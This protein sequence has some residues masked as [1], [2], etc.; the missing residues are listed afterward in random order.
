M[1]HP[2]GPGPLIRP[3]R[4]RTDW[5]SV[6]AGIGFTLLVVVAFRSSPRILQNIDGRVYDAFLRRSPHLPAGTVPV[7]VDIDEESLARYGQWPW[8]RY[9]VAQLLE[10]VRDL[11]ASAVALDVVFAEPDRTSLPLI[12]REIERDLGVAV[13]LGETAGRVADNDQR[14]A[15]VLEKGPFVL[16]Y[17]FDFGPG[18]GKTPD[19]CVLHPLT[20]NPS[21]RG[22]WA[23]LVRAPQVVCNL[24]Q[25]A[26]AAGA[27]GFFNVAPDPDGTLR[28]V[29]LLIEYR[30]E[31][32]PSL[33]LA[34][35]VRAGGETTVTLE[36]AGGA[37][38]R[39]KVAGREI[40]LGGYGKML[41][42]F[43]GPG[44][45]YR[46]LS[47]AAVLEG[48]VPAATLA[49]RIAFV[50]TTAAGLKEL[51]ATPFDP[52]YP[53]PEVHAAALDTILQGD[54]LQRPRAAHGWELLAA[55]FAGAL[56]TLV[57][58]RSGA[59]AGLPL[60]LLGSAA[61][62]GGSF[63]LFAREG[64]FVSPLIPQSVLAGTFALLSFLRFRQSER[65]AAAFARKLSLTQ[66]VIIQSMAA[67]AETRDSGTGGHIQRTRHYVKLLA[68]LLRNH[69]RFREYLDPWTIELLY[70]LAP[71]HDIGKVGVRDHVLLKPDRLSS[72][73]FEEMK[74][75]TI[76]GDNTLELAERHLGD[77]SFLKIAR[78]FAL[79]HQEKWDGTGYPQDL[80]GEQIPIAGRLMAVADVYDALVS[81][82]KYKE[83]LSHE[84]AVAILAEGRGT[85]FDPDVLDVFLAHQDQF[86]MIAARFADAPGTGS[87]A[88]EK[89]A[90]GDG[91]RGAV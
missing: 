83:P 49:G 5:R 70:K 17:A 69:P 2:P 66:D 81:R 43:R 61:L 62:W 47:A 27:S 31:V 9:R 4:R 10:R 15:E 79:T 12:A 29:P 33:A 3:P 37:V 80:A 38:P 77:D 60:L 57:L 45:G 39:L 19:A 87:A 84:R 56:A 86:K 24:P 52:V 20:L 18:P 32:Y 51:R 55:L 21:E 90:A 36:S 68:E 78:E 74:R 54:F 16:G 14:L 23:R 6:I 44:R 25:F 67:L 48:R 91:L 65:E 22:D 73:E 8:P 59:I 40:P 30:G 11:G 42:R 82:R 88:M 7:V 89:A 64:L 76:F 35:L 53:G 72:A 41:V 28:G 46:Y 1:T 13:N 34:A 71:L 58:S 26:R 63:W 50:G 85:H 75:H